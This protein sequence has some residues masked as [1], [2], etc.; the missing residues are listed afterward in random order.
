MFYINNMTQMS[1]N[2]KEQSKIRIKGRIPLCV[3]GGTQDGT[4]SHLPPPQDADSPP[5]QADL[6]KVAISPRGGWSLKS[7][8]VAKRGHVTIVDL[9]V[10]VTIF[11][12][13][14]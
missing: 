10:K 4:P 6:G 5:K 11:P 1:C 9:G 12:P 7:L 13:I 14:P 2:F 8:K 3:G